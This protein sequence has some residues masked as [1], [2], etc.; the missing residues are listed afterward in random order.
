MHKLICILNFYA[1][2]GLQCCYY[3]R[4]LPLLWE[5]QLGRR[6]GNAAYSLGAEGCFGSLL[7]R[8][9][10]KPFLRLPRCYFKKSMVFPRQAL[11]AA[12]LRGQRA[13]GPGVGS[14][15]QVSGLGADQ[16][17]W[18]DWCPQSSWW[19]SPGPGLGLGSR[20]AGEQQR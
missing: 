2:S 12:G 13:G 6:R 1:L 14:A 7:S 19:A 17:S 9:L 3:K 16:A 18:G 8:A 4:L 20:A 5:Q 11:C 15:A 10:Q